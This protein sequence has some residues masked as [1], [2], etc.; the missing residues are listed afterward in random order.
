M[1]CLLLPALTELVREQMI[2]EA[3]ERCGSFLPK[4]ASHHQE[5]FSVIRGHRFEEFQQPFRMFRDAGLLRQPGWPGPTRGFEQ[6][7]VRF[8]A[9][10]LCKLFQGN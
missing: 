3:F 4:L 5:Y 2:P 7:L 6:H 10:R 8:Y 9:E 1:N